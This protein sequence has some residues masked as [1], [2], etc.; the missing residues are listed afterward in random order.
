MIAVH[1]YYNIHDK[2]CSYR[3]F[4]IILSTFSL[5]NTINFKTNYSGFTSDTHCIKFRH[6]MLDVT[7][8]EGIPR[9]VVSCTSTGARLHSSCKAKL[10]NSL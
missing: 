6:A 2:V 10:E 8:L 3:L 5:L 7:Q 1:T 4:S 9:M